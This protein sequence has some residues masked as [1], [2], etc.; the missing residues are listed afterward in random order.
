MT[1]TRSSNLF[2]VLKS[3]AGYLSLY[4]YIVRTTDNVQEEL[5]HKPVRKVEVVIMFQLLLMD[6][7]SQIQ[8]VVSAR[9][10]F[11]C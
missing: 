3:K 1:Y 6:I 5:A 7:Y 2:A 10:F 4:L 8:V 9:K 11:Y